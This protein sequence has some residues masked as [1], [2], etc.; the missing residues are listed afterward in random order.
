MDDGEKRTRN[1]AA[2]RAAIERAARQHFMRR[3]YEQ[4]GLRDIARD[5][6]V[7]AALI[8]RYFGSKEGLFETAVLPHFSLDALIEGDIDRFPDRAAAVSVDPAH[9][10]DKEF[11]VSLAFL[12][13]IGNPEVGPKIAEQVSR[14]MVDRLA[15]RLDGAEAE[16]R[17]ALA[18]ATLLGFDALHRIAALDVLVKTDRDAL[19]SR[20]ARTLRA[21]LDDAGADGT[22]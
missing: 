21:S 5:A 22:A 16:Q 9:G 19:A 4:V 15:G 13:S 14:A 20:L 3:G 8:S 10:R 17:A 11:D 12:L 1:A 18:L 7:D 2:T 6:G